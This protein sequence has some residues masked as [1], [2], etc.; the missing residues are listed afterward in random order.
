MYMGVPPPSLC[1]VLKQEDDYLR[2][3]YPRYAD[4]PSAFAVLSM[5]D[6]MEAKDRT[7]AQIMK[8]V[9]KLGITAATLPASGNG[10]S[11]NEQEE[12]S[13]DD[14]TL[15]VAPTSDGE[16]DKT[17]SPVRVRKIKRKSQAQ[18]DDDSDSMFSSLEVRACVLKNKSSH[19]PKKSY[20]LGGLAHF[21]PF[22]RDKMTMVSLLSF[23]FII[24]RKYQRGVN[25]RSFFTVR[26]IR[27][28]NELQR[29]LAGRRTKDQGTRGDN[30]TNR[31]PAEQTSTA[32]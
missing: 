10:E 1:L 8:R 27:R 11:E 14:D 21:Q 3:Q 18:S 9:K 4:T 16:E 30:A 12:G 7:E 15:Q 26:L 5:A 19:N 24:A 28:S 17:P 13:G 2:E 22:L 20:L 29:S 6:E 23:L 32:R 25:G 31:A